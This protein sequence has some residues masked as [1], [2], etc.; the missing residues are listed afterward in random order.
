MTESRKLRKPSFAS[1]LIGLGGRHSV[2]R[3]V[4][5][6]RL[7]EREQRAASDTRTEAQRWLGDPPPTQS[8]LAQNNGAKLK[9]DQRF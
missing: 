6:T 5:R 4:L 1:A 3:D 2:N 8:A 9:S 7:Q